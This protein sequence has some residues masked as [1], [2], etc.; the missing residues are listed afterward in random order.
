M[1]GVTGHAQT[2]LATALDTT[3]VVWTTGGHALWTGQTDVTHDGVDAAR[4][5]GI[6]GNQ[7]SWVQTVI[8]GVTNISFW[9]KVSSEEGFDEL[10]FYVDDTIPAAISGPTVPWEQRS[11]QLNPGSHTLKWRYYKDAD[12]SD[13]SDCGWLDQVQLA[14]LPP[15]PPVFLTQPTN[16]TAGVG[17]DT[18]LVADVSGFPFPTY[19][20]R[21]NGVPVT[22]ATSVSLFLSNV[23]PAQAGDY[24]LVASNALN[25]V[26][27]TNAHLTVLTLA[28]GLDSTGLAWTTGGA[29]GWH[30]VVGKTHDGVDAAES[31]DISESQESWMQTSVTGPGSLTFWWKVSSESNRFGFGGDALEFSID[32]AV[33]SNILGEVA[34]QSNA[35]AITAGVHT[36]RWRYVKD[37]SLA[38]GED[39][40]WVDQVQWV[41]AAPQPFKLGPPERQGDGAFR[42]NLFGEKGRSYK[43]QT[44]I[45]LRTWDDLTGYFTSETNLMT[46]LDSQAKNKP[47]RFYRAV[48]WPGGPLPFRLG[49]SRS[50]TGG[51]AMVTLFGESG[52]SYT[53]QRSTNLITWEDLSTFSTGSTN[54]VTVW[55]N[56]ATNAPRRFYRGLTQ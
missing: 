7:E 15:T 27:S 42:L 3:N 25:S 10:E 28:E 22:G 24:T 45:N 44:S 40:G 52:R 13:G 43:I 34:W 1:T 37:G 47:L 18:W 12:A 36:L 39:R 5:G 31:G 20:W 21:L 35:Y 11:F 55:D 50:Q 19:Q 51:V 14:T 23:S 56:Q 4:S 48:V 8:S 30:T 41:A 6:T 29:R 9:W 17:G 46:V 33:R 26:T 16:Q 2:L 54:V 53:I 32:G 38:E 49:L